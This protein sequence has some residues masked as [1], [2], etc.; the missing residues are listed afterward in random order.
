M[1][2]FAHI[3][4]K[5]AQKYTIFSKVKKGQ[6]NWPNG[7][8]ISLPANRFNKT[9]WQPCF[10]SNPLD[11]LGEFRFQADLEKEITK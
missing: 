8:I 10:Q 11:F 1:A 7:Q 3:S 9:K 4:T 5:Q 6:K 2:S